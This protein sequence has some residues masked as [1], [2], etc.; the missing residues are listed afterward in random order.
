MTIWGIIIGGAAGFAMGGPIGALLGAAAGHVAERGLKQVIAPEQTRNVAFTVAVIALSAKMARTDGVVTKAEIQAFRARVHIPEKDIKQVAKF[1][2]L[3]RQTQDGFQAYAKQTVA[4]FGERA[5]ILEQLLDL[6][7]CIAKA[8]GD[9]TEP[10]WDYLTEVA[11]IFGYDEADFARFTEIY[12]HDDAMPHQI[13]GIKRDA[14]LAEVRAAWMQLVKDHHPDQLIAK[15]MPSEF[16]ESA[17][18]RLA[19]I[20]RAY[21]LMRSQIQAQTG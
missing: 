2:D 21:E 1:W 9:I 6:L 18:D 7:F 19:R 20:N 16:I 10:E 12:A 15:G 8:D 4:L 5:A 14:S 11:L 3:A 13:L 17:T